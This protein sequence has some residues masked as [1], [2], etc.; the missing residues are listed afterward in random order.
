MQAILWLP[1][2]LFV[3]IILAI[4]VFCVLAGL[5]LVL[6]LRRLGGP[7]GE[8]LPQATFVSVT[9]TAWALS[10]GFAAS[11]IF[12]LNGKADQAALEE[13]SSVMRILGTAAPEALNLPEMHRIVAAY[14]EAVLALEAGPN[15]NRAAA[16]EVE[17][18]LQELR[19]EI[20]AMRRHGIA[21]VIIGKTVRD[22]DE[23]QDARNARLAVG[24]SAVDDTKWYLVFAL[25]L[26]TALNI[27]LVNAHAPKAARNALAIYGT[28]LFLCVVILGINSDPY[29]TMRLNLPQI[30]P[31][32]S[33]DDGAPTEG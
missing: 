14:S 29:R 25:S 27:G 33:A 31:A 2:P 22:F 24:Q 28:A 12:A 19:V 21:D 3:L 10:L 23:L 13:R 15:R 4:S 16:P 30:D 5:G 32:A 17:A 1:F 20:I 9:A 6:L 8:R 11:D 7:L 26:L 18:L